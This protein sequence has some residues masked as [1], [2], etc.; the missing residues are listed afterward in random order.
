[1]YN[2]DM[3]TRA[4]LP[5]RSKLV[6]STLIAIVAAAVLLI[7]VVLPAEYAVDPTGV[8]K[9]LGLTDMGQIKQQLADEAEE[10][11]AADKFEAV[12]PEAVEPKPMEVPQPAVP[13]EIVWTDESVVSLN[14]GEAAEVKLV[15]KKG[16][17]VQ[18]VW[19]V[20]QG[21]LNSDLHTDDVAGK[22]H[23]Y[24]QGRAETESSGD[25][26]AVSEGAHG[27]YWRNRSDETVTVTL[28]V[29]GQYSEL[30]RMF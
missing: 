19:A 30:K 7:T 22:A 11:Q 10:D 18:Y 25:F 17:T 26:T 28:K 20:D 6:R 29:R 14:P 9:A 23:S 1:M 4:E 5:T 2:T 8:G 16:D 27:W 21:H 15:M 13:A 24:N 3:P 12:M